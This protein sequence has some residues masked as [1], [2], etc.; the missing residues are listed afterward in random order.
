MRNAS[1]ATAMRTA[2]NACG[3][4]SRNAVLMIEKFEAPDDGHQ[5]QKAVERR[6]TGGF[7]QGFKGFT[8]FIQSSRVQ[9]VQGS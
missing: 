2:L 9:R 4:S 8:G 5:E 1:E 7:V 3:S 6:E